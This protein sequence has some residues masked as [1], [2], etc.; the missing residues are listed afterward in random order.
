MATAEQ[1]Q[2]LWIINHLI[3]TIRTWL[4]T[5]AE[6]VWGEWETDVHSLASCS[7]AKERSNTCSSIGYTCQRHPQCLSLAR[8]L[9]RALFEPPFIHSFLD[10]FPHPVISQWQRQ[11]C[12]SDLT[13]KTRLLLW[14]KLWAMLLS[15]NVFWENFLL[16]EM[17]QMNLK[18]LKTPMIL[19]HRS[20]SVPILGSVL[21][22]TLRS[23]KLWRM[24]WQLYLQQKLIHIRQSVNWSAHLC[25]K[26]V[27]TFEEYSLAMSMSAAVKPRVPCLT[28]LIRKVVP[29]ITT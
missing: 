3:S 10:S 1:I 15:W 4:L 9:L 19:L 7:P 22:L 28:W 21:S 6:T 2:W 27:R 12:H 18:F 24:H 20:A 17:Y 29:K 14:P 13:R 8:Q 5:L 25:T 26:V 16:S 11:Q 23:A